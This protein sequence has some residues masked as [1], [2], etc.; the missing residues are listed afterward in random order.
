MSAAASGPRRCPNCHAVAN[1]HFCP[2]CGQPTK[3]LRAG[4]RDLVH[5]FAGAA[6]GAD[7]RIWASLK[8]LFRHPG[9][10]TVAYFE[11]RRF[12]YLSPLR[13][14]L[15]ASVLMFMVTAL[16]P[17]DEGGNVT[18][19]STDGEQEPAGMEYAIRED[20]LPE[21]GWFTEYFGDYLLEWGRHMDTMTHEQQEQAIIAQISDLAPTALFLFLPFL[22]AILRL[23]WVRRDFLYFDHFIFALNY[24]SFIYLLVV[25]FDLFSA[26]T[27]L[28]GWV[29]AIIAVTYPPFYFVRA[30]QRITDLGTGRVFAASVLTFFL[31]LPA[32][33]VLSLGLVLIGALSA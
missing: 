20:I 11:G 30:Q 5:D 32:A 12:R 13:L 1:H 7:A 16:T 21:D 18:F 15:F 31:A 10:L 17:G 4:L 19:T 6:F 9:A 27:P 23:V 28:P 33:L 14:Y 8:Q 3:G 22:A 24:M 26:L 29:I 2:K 25:A